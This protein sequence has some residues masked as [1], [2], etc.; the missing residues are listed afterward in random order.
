MCSVFIRWLL[1]ALLDFIKFL[2]QLGKRGNVGSIFH[3]TKQ[4]QRDVAICPS[5]PS[6]D[7]HVGLLPSTV[8]GLS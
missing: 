6:Q 8:L 4:K 5:W 1:E 7:S 2:Q 3:I